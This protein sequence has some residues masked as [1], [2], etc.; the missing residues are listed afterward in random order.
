MIA[1]AAPAWL[2]GLSAAV[3][4]WAMALLLVVMGILGFYMVSVED[5]PDSVWFFDTYNSVGLVMA[6]LIAVRC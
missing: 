4:H 5:E 2:Y 1:T 3:L 6:F